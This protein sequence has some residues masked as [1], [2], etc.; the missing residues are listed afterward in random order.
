MAAASSTVG[1]LIRDELQRS[2][3]VASADCCQETITGAP[4]PAATRLRRSLR[5]A[6]TTVT[7]PLRSATWPAASVTVRRTV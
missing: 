7:L 3:Q 4:R 1:E 5:T 2:A 6:R